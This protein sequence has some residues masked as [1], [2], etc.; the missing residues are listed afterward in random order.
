M[1]LPL[2]LCER[3]L[4]RWCE[5]G[6]IQRLGVGRRVGGEAEEYVEALATSVAVESGQR[7]VLL[8][9]PRIHAIEV[10]LYG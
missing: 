7:I 3:P 10:T 5:R 9:R 2:P 1:N 4:R 6:R 8:I